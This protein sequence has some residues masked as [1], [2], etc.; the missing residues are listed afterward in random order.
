[1]TIMDLRQIINECSCDIIFTINGKE[2][3]IVSEVHNYIPTF[4]AWCED[5]IKEYNSVD[6]LMN[7]KFF[8]GKSLI[9]LANKT[10]FICL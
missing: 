7:D 8:D 4:R 2:S 5:N 9:Q 3:G 1:M 6:T 10:T